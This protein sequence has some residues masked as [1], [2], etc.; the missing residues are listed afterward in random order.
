VRQLSGS[1]GRPKSAAM[2]PSQD[3]LMQTYRESMKAAREIAQTIIGL[4]DTYEQKPNQTTMNL[5]LA[6]V[7]RLA[8]LAEDVEVHQ[9]LK[10]L[11]G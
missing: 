1:L 7:E 8:N 5:F 4:C 3:T 11:D 9:T 10:A 2:P 6:S